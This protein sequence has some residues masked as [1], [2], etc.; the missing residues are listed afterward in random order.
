[1][2]YYS[3]ERLKLCISL[4]LSLSS[5]P[6]PDDAPGDLEAAI[7]TARTCLLTWLL[8]TVPNGVLISHTITYNLTSNGG[9]GGEGEGGRLAVVTVGGEETNVLITD[10]HPYEYY[11]FTVF[12]STR[13]GSSP[14]STVAIRTEE[15]SEYN[16]GIGHIPIPDSQHVST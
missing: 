3:H 12:A 4:S 11:Q 5:R 8:P 10:L 1:M 6:V 13:I 15:A 14:V 7:V 2:Y 16:Y 9:G